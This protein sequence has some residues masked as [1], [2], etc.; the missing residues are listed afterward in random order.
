MLEKYIA[1]IPTTSDK[2]EWLDNGASWLNEKTDKDIYLEME[3]PK[4][5][6]RIAIK[7]EMDY[8][9]KGAKLMS[10]LGDVLQLR[11]TESLREKEGGT[12][13]AS[14]RA[15]LTKK[16]KTQAYLSVSFDGNPEKVE[17][18]I[19]L[20]HNDIHAIANGDI[21]QSDLDKTLTNYLKEREEAKNYN[22]YEM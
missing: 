14:S 15:H 21:L 11:L 4:A 19:Q 22:N 10:A 8:S 12:Y 2:E 20:V 18:L 7:N 1:S 6:V 13:G 5:T 9:L 16:P 3:D 17:D